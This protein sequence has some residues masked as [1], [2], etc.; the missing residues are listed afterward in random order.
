MNQSDITTYLASN[1]V[2]QGAGT[3]TMSDI[4]LQKYLAMGC[5]IENWNDMRRF[6]FSAG[7][8]GGFGVVYPSHHEAV[9]LVCRHSP[10]LPVSAQL[11]PGVGGRLMG[12]TYNHSRL[13]YMQ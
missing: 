7:N 13:N 11:I 3:L 4:M 5:S 1:A 9:H 10:I 8:I 12:I 2:A 6:N